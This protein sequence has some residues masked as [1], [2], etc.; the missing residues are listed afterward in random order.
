PA[1]YDLDQLSVVLLLIDYTTG[2]IVNSREAKVTTN[3]GVT[4]LPKQDIKMNVY[5]NPASNATNVVFELDK[6]QDVLLN[7]YTLDGKVVY[8]KNYNSLNGKQL[9]N[10][11]TSNL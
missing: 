11:E 10:I 3:A 9:L 2:N 8:S 4:E 7:V 5:P 6:V 1:G